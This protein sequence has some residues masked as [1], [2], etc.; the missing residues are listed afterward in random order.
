MRPNEPVC[1]CV[2]RA[3]GGITRTPGCVLHDLAYGEQREVDAPGLPMLV[4]PLRDEV[5]YTVGQVI[6]SLQRLSVTEA[7]WVV[8]A[9]NGYLDARK[10]GED[11]H[12][13]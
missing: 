4:H 8:G 10:R 11:D 7:R 1:T 12:S 3:G 13:R 9:A 2:R 6:M 5:A